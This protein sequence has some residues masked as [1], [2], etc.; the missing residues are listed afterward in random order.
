MK[1]ISKLATA[2][3]ISTPVLVSAQKIGAP[4]METANLF[5]SLVNT[6]NSVMPIL[7]VLVFA[8]GVVW[9]VWKK[10]TGGEVENKVLL[11]GVIA[12]AILFSLSGIIKLMQNIIGASG[13]S[14]LVAPVVVVPQMR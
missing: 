12:L 3:L 9:Y 14:A 8:M 7:A 6:L 1:N 4:L 5:K 10:M 13:S 2:L 11:W